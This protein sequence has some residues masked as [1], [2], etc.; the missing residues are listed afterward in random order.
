MESSSVVATPYLD[1]MVLQ[2]AGDSLMMKIG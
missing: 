2:E 1:S